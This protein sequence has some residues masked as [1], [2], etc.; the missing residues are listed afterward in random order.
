MTRFCERGIC[1]KKAVKKYMVSGFRTAFVI[2]EMALCSDCV[3]VMQ[4]EGHIFTS[5][6]GEEDASS[7]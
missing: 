6:D 1:D 3:K 5:L 4:E 7:H 2:T